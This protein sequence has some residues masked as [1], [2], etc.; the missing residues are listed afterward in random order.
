MYL[1]NRRKFDQVG[2]C[3]A[4]TLNILHVVHLNGLL[5]WHIV[6]DSLIHCIMSICISS[7]FV[8]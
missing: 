6:A 2:S 4:M 5:P 7:G 1:I 8:V 3:V